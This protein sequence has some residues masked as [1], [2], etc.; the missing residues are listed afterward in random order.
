L[1]EMAIACE[2]QPLVLHV[3]G[4]RRGAGWFH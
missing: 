3:E 2:G 4:R 1:L